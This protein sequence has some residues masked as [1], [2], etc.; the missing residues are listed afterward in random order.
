[1]RILFQGDSITDAHRMPQEV[2]PAFQLG[3][4]YVLMVAAELAVRWP[5]SGWKFVN[6]GVSGN[7]LADLR[8]RWEADALEVRP[9]VLS[10]LAGVNDTYH[11]FQHR[12]KADEGQI[13]DDYRYLL[14]SSLQVNPDLKLIMMEP[15]VLEC[16][17]ADRRWRDHLAPRQQA[18]AG[19]AAEYGAEFLPLQSVFDEASE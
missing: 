6:R 7:R 2:N 9:D 12:V 18:I 10:L 16:G 1:M 13:A 19:L 15:F 8:K 11:F 4:G 5:G 14:E 3:A 17:V